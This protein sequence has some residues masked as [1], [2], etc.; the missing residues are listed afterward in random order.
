MECFPADEDDEDLAANHDRVDGDEKPVSVNTLEDVELVVQAPIAIHVSMQPLAGRGF[1][2]VLV[3][4]LHPDECVEDEGPELLQLF[5]CLV[6]EDSRAAEI[7]NKG[8]H[9]LEDGLSDNHLPHV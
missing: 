1:L 9:E 3:E 5:W 2:L 8:D 7:E 4:N 6:V